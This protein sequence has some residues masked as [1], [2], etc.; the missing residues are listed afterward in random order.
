MGVNVQRRA[1]VGMTD[2]A[3]DAGQVDHLTAEIAW[4]RMM[5]MA[6]AVQ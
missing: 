3:L 1:Q 6:F 2:N 5:V 4:N